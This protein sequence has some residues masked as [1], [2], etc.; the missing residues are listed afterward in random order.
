MIAAGIVVALPAAWALRRLVQAELFGVGAFDGPTIAAAGGGLTIV[1]LAATMLPAWRA[2]VLPPMMAIRNEPESIWQSARQTVERKIHALVGGEPSAVPSVT[3]IDEFTGLVQRAESFPEALRVA[4]PALGERVGARFITLL[5]KTSDGE[6]RNEERRQ[7]VPGDRDDISIPARGVL[8]NRLTHFRHPLPL[9]AGDLQAWLR[10]AREFRPEHVAEIERLEHTGARIAVAL[11]TKRGIVGVLLLAPDGDRE[12]FTDA[13]KQVLSSAAEVFALMIEN[14]RLNDR[15]LEQEKVRRDLALAA[16]VQRRLLPP[17]PPASAIGTMAAF[18]MPARAIGG[19]FYD[20]VDLPDNR[21]GIALADIAGKGIAAALLTSVVQASLRVISDESDIAPAQL[22][23][24]M[25]R[26]LHRATASN[27]YATFFYAQLDATARR[28][29]Y[30][31]AGHNPPYLV[32]RTPAAVEVTELAVGGMVL[33]LFP[34]VDYEDAAV[35]IQT[36]DLFVAFT[37]GVTEARNAVG[38]EFGEDRLK[39]LLRQHA[40]APA[41]AV[42]SL[43]ADRMQEWIAGAEQH[44]D[45]TFV[46]VAVDVLAAGAG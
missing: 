43:L 34:D 23:S 17:Q 10:W 39:D 44:D 13:E 27:G 3:L 2:A 40:G 33:G 36:G 4:L 21:I 6:Y 18:T 20:F 24:R 19:D 28:M 46:V 16:E 7:G 25:N 41:D 1:A 45:L 35:D 22:A 38:E 29:R 37:D 11:R 5:E 12:A 14:A 30:V 42:S 9:T 32:R 15:A 31:N 8:V 26:F